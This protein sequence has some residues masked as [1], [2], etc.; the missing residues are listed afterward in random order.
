MNVAGSFGIIT[1]SFKYVGLVRIVTASLI[2]FAA[3]V[4]ALRF[5]SRSAKPIAIY[6]SIFS[7]IFNRSVDVEEETIEHEILSIDDEDAVEELL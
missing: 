6:V 1:S 2:S 7:S 5:N 4:N 3:L